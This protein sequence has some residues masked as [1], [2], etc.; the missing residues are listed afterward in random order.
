[1]IIIF[2]TKTGR[3][4]TTFE[5]ATFYDHTHTHM[6]FIALMNNLGKGLEKLHLYFRLGRGE[7]KRF[8]RSKNSMTHIKGLKNVTKRLFHSQG[9]MLVVGVEMVQVLKSQV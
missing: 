1:M 5:K 3:N 9:L 6:H 7:H 8:S 2:L 4:Q